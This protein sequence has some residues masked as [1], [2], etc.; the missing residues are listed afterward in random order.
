MN[1]TI[2]LRRAFACAA[3]AGL[4]TACTEAPA[5]AESLLEHAAKHPDPG[6]V[7]PMHPEVSSAEPGE[8]PICGM[9][10][11]E[12]EPSVELSTAEVASLGVRV[13]PARLG[14]LERSLRT[15]GTVAFD[16]R[17]EI[18]VRV[19]AEGYVESLAVRAEGERVRRG[20]ALFEVFSPRLAAAQREYL[21]LLANGDEGLVAAAEARL[22]ALGLTSAAV[23]RLRTSATVE[24]RVAYHSPVEGVVLALGVREGALAQPGISAL[25]LADVG[26][27]WVIADVPETEAGAVALGADTTLTFPS[28]PGR[29]FTAR[30]AER[31]PAL[32]LAARTFQVRI[33]VEN[34]ADE[35]SAGMRADVSIRATPAAERVLVP[36]EAVIRTGTEDRLLV[37]TRSGAYEARVVHVGAESGGVVEILHGLEAGERVVVSGQFMLD[38]ETRT[39]AGLA[40][41][42]SE[43]AGHAGHVP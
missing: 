20:Q 14:R 28:L 22:A 3:L 9:D 37:A 6:Y 29:R 38:S 43:P 34:P 40:R 27:L 36:L 31:L 15:V 30:V 24:A 32:N 10:L 17:A 5:P 4:L 23:D 2:T 8:C 1:L 35:L 7:C 12:R 11:V 42:G 21:Q 39:R 26:R 18:E 16:E 25:T 19:R 13:E 33:P 41:F